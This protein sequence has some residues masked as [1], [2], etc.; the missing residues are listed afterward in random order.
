MLAY[1]GTKISPNMIETQDEFLICK[2][3]PIGRIG[4]MQYLA[5]ELQ[6]D[7]DPNALITVTRDEETVFEPA[8][9]ASFEGKP[10]T[11]DHPLEEVTADNYAQY[12]KG[13]VQNVRRGTG[14]WEGY[15]MADLFVADRNLINAIQ[16]GKREVSC[17]YSCLYEANGDGTYR[18]QKIRGNHVA[19]VDHGRAGKT[20]SI[21]DSKQQERRKTMKK[22]RTRSILSM[23]ARA[24]KDAEPSELDSIAEDA[25]EVLREGKPESETGSD[26][27]ITSTQDNI[28]EMLKKIMEMLTAKEEKEAEPKPEDEIDAMINELTGEHEAD[29]E[30]ATT[31]P[32]EEMDGCNAVNRDTAITIL[33]HARQAVAEIKDPADRKRVT[34]ALLASV[35]GQVGDTMG[36]IMAATKKSAQKAAEDGRAKEIDYEKQQ[37][38]Y[39][40]FNPHIKE[41]K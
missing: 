29:S 40:A 6:L 9:L 28:G 5:R 2:N 7:G 38:A 36:E 26:S 4:T 41:A 10:V 3:V 37:G 34:D 22:D 32:A 27:D 20:V 33:K 16:S 19:V 12:A 8:T 24:A 18:Q 25:A 1:Y 13:H 14:E 30:E 31:V 23:F 15:I 11:D 21:H 35:R 17:G 39:N